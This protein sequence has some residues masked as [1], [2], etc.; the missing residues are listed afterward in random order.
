[1][2]TIF[3]KK[4]SYGALLLC[5]FLLAG[6]KGAAVTIDSPIDG[7]LLEAGSTSVDIT[8][9][10]EESTELAVQLNGVDITSLMQ[11]TPTGSIGVIN[12]VLPGFN[13]L[14]VV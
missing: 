1:M 7:S 4:V 6:C 9:N 3:S 2:F 8:Y 14:K 10:D 12:D 5:V 13:V 11:T